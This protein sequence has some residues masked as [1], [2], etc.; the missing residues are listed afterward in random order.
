MICQILKD[1][2]FIL[3]INNNNKLKKIYIYLYYYN[4]KMSENKLSTIPQVLS[5]ISSLEEM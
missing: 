2:K 5:K 3:L 1:C 4:R